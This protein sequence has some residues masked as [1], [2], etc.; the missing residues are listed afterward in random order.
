[1]TTQPTTSLFNLLY[2]YCTGTTTI[3]Q[4]HTCQ[5]T[6]ASTFKPSFKIDWKNLSLQRGAI[7][8]GYIIILVCILVDDEADTQASVAGYS[9]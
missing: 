3:Q 1:M 9:F 2:V 8:I 5:T 6:A 4:S 7:L